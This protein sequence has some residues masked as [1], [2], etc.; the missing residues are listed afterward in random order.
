MDWKDLLIDSYSAA[1]K[2]PDIETLPNYH[3][4]VLERSKRCLTTLSSSDLNQ[5]IDDPWS[6][7][8]PTVGS[9]LVITLDEILQHASQLHK[10]REQYLRCAKMLTTHNDEN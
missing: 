2:S 4:A 7:L 10:V 9:R 6:Q 5:D 3:R 8:F 1:F